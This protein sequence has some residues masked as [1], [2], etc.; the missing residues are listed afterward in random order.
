MICTVNVVELV[1]TGTVLA[2]AVNVIE[3]VPSTQEA[4]IVI[5]GV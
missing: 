5:D 4:E 1:V 2:D 3:Y